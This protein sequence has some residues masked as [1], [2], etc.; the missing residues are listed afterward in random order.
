MSTAAWEYHT[1]YVKFVMGHLD[2]HEIDDTLNR[3]AAEGWELVH[4]TPVLDEAKTVGL[5]HQFR[6]PSQSERRAGFTA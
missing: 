5:L 2:T 4:V 1:C 3:L 6:R